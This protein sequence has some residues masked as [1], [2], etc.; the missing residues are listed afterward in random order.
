M[1]PN[2]AIERAMESVAAAAPRA[3]ADPARPVYHFRPPAQWMNDPNGVIYHNGWYQ[4]FYQ[5]NPFGDE[6]GHIH[7]GHARSRD[8][9][10]WE[11]LPIALWPSQEQGEAHCFSG[12]AAVNGRGEPMLFYTS[13]FGPRENRPA[14]Q[15]WAALG[16]PDW[17]TWRKYPA[18][19][20][21]SL[22]NHGGPPFEGDWR[23]PFIFVEEGRTFLVLGG[24]YEN[25][26]GVA[27]YEATDETLAHWRYRSLLY[28]QPRDQVGFLECPNFTRLGEK[29]ILLTSPYRPV[30]YVTGTFD[31]D[32]LTFVPEQQGIL[33]PGAT[34]VPNYYATNIL[35]DDTGR[36]ILL[37]WV[38]GFPPGRGWNG[39]LALPRVLT[40]GADGLPRQQPVAEL[41]QL[42]DRHFSAE[43]VALSAQPLVLAEATGDTVEV[44]ARIALESSAVVCVDLCRPTGG[45]HAI[46]IR[47]DGSVLTVAETEVPLTLEN[48]V[49]DLHLFLDKSVLEVFA[50]DGR[51]VVTRVIEPGAGGGDVAFSTKGGAATLVSLDLWTM[52]PVW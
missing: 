32:T 6:W 3:A 4:L 49:L 36:C 50:Q 46:P 34:D 51:V 30:K 28:Q 16:D 24:V 27:L 43:G 37:G 29:W 13:V 7:W 18:N 11:Y 8:L 25:I 15:Q 21:L 1:E 31:F 35:F 5:F 14:N 52:R 41:Q 2:P 39:C 42:R 26:A 45:D 10:Q 33:D 48:G 44:Q 38:R 17:L 12:C 47:Y 9:V 22:A 40:L 20:I 19:P 23:D